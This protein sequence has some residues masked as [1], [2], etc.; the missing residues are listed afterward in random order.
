MDK[1]YF[2]S[3]LHFCHDKDFVWAPRGF[4]S[5]HEMN[6][7]I[8]ENWNNTVNA[9]DTIYVLGDLMLKDD[10]MGI[11][12]IK[13]LKGNIH[14]IRGNHDSNNRMLLYNSCYNIV[15]MN[16]GQFFKY[17]GYN[18]FLSHY[19]CLCANGDIDKPLKARTISLCGH[20]HITNPFADWDKGLIYHCEL[21]AHNNQLVLIDDIIEDIKKEINK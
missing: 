7:T 9:N 19:P 1:I 14:V 10:E 2:T 12:F 21:D 8:I 15:D 11:K 16:E 6:Q 17:E 18:F 3:D 13:S 5:V 20:S 4:S